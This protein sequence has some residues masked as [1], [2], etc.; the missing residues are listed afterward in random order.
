MA[1]DSRDNRYATCGHVCAKEKHL[2]RPDLSAPSEAT[3][4]L[5]RA[6]KS[7]VLLEELSALL[8]QANECILQEPTSQGHQHLQQAGFRRLPQ[9]YRS[10]Y[11]DLQVGDLKFLARRLK[12][13]KEPLQWGGSPNCLLPG[14]EEPPK[15][16]HSCRP[17]RCATYGGGQGCSRICRRYRQ[18]CWH[19]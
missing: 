15:P 13:K 18:H 4:T 16:A 3:V 11:Q 17:A 8:A 1:E 9:L 7:E 14:S 6:L 12:R 5:C 19:F 10:A 2:L